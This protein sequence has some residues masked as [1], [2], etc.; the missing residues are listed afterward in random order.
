[1]FSVYDFLNICILC[2]FF[3]DH[4]NIFIF[5]RTMCYFYIIFGNSVLIYTFDFAVGLGV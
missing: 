2:I 3:F 4:Y 5:Q 1:M